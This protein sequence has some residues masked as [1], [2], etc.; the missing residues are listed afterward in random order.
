[1]SLFC[2]NLAPHYEPGTEV[3]PLPDYSEWPDAIDRERGRLIA[4][5]VEPVLFQEDKT[6]FR[7]S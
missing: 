2:L 1:M 6:E 4:E 7:P 3:Y 5:C